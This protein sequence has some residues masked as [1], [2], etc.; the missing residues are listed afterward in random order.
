MAI[1]S[2]VVHGNGPSG[3]DVVQTALG[4]L[5]R[6]DEEH[7]AVY[8]QIVYNALREP[9]RQ[10]L[11]ALIME[12]QTEAKATFPP[13]AQQ[14]IERGKREGILE[15]KREALFRLVARARIALTEEDRARILACEDPATL[16]RWFDNALGAKTTADVFS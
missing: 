16:D 13:F 6:F 8:F 12:R 3:L 10:A 11:E 5:G 1:L 14:L 4:A 15:G 7:A 9:V 2:A